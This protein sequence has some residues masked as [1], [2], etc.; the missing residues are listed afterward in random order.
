MDL[1]Y[2]RYASP[3]SF[4]DGMIQ[5]GRFSEFV[6]SLVKTVNEEREE[7][8]QWEFWLHKVWDGTYEKFKEE[9]KNNKENLS[10][11]KRTIETTIQNSM[12]IL[13][14]FNPQKEGGEK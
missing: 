11:S 9:I 3:F 1:L 5:T 10:M 12:D 13:K 4:M 14:N 8:A 6:E 2:Q 7:K